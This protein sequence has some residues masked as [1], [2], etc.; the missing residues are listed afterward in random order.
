ML[1]RDLGLRDYVEVVNDMRRFTNSRDSNTEDELWFVQ[2]PAVFTLG[3]AG[4]PEHV[5]A[6]GDIPV[7]KVERGGQ[8]TFHAPGQ[9]VVYTLLDLKRRKLG[10]RDLVCRLEQALIDSLKQLGIDS[11]R[12]KG[13]PGVYV[14]DGPYAGA[15]I[16]ALGLKVTRSCCFH[17]LALN[18]AMDLEPFSRINPCGYPGL[19]V[20]QVKDLI[21]GSSI[22]SNL[23]ANE[24]RIAL[25]SQTRPILEQC[26]RQQLA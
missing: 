2:H 12:K 16:A 14:S 21:S 22:E 10:V 6:P 20:T 4:K 26:L 23:T 9:W 18:V 25:L 17:G 8:V 5:L 13:A 3:Q 15:K 11:Q 19:A 24:V 1:S 7:I